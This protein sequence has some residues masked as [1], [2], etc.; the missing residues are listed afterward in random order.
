M[1]V[2]FLYEIDRSTWPKHWVR[3]FDDY[4]Q[5]WE[6]VLRSL[7]DAGQ[8]VICYGEDDRVQKIAE[9]FSCT[10]KHFPL[11]QWSSFLDYE[12]TEIA[13]HLKHSWEV[14]ENFSAV[15][16]C[17]QLSKFD[18][19]RLSMEMFPDENEWVW[20]DGGL[21]NVGMPKSWQVYWKEPKIQITCFKPSAGNV[22]YFQTPKH[23]YV[24]GTCFGAN[25]EN[26]L[27]LCANMKATSKSL[28]EDKKCANDQQILS[29]LHNSQVHQ[30]M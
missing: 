6:S 7:H 19:L 5:R 14:P 3:P 23:T 25:R 1:Y 10:Y 28:L 22:N 15:Y 21:R 13:V 16:I 27:W 17:L 20:V 30:L 11:R 9:Q 18:A 29:M 24:M 2:T 4:L 8:K 12:R 26:M